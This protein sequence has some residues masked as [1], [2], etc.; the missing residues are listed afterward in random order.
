ML[1]KE[2]FSYIFPCDGMGKGEGAIEIFWLWMHF[3]W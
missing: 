3:I 1:Y 2:G